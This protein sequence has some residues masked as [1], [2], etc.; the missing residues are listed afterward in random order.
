MIEIEIHKT[1]RLSGIWCSKED[2]LELMEGGL[3]NFTEVLREDN[4]YFLEECGGISGLVTSA[5]WVDE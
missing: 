3:D 5:R 1:V 2:F 4:S